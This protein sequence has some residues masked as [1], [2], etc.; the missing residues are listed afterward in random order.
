MAK[1]PKKSV[2]IL[3]GIHSVTEAL[4]AGRREF[5]EIYFSR[6]LPESIA[7]WARKRNVPVIGKS[8]EE[9]GKLAGTDQHQHVAAKV[10]P[11]L[12]ESLSRLI[13]HDIAG[14][15]SP[16]YVLIDS[17]E[18]PRNMGA[19]I[20]TS[21]C[22][23]VSGVIVPKDRCAPLTPAVSRASAGAMEHCRLC[24]VTNLTG[25]IKELKKQNVWITGLDRKGHLSIYD[26]DMTGACAIVVGGEHTGIRRL[27][28][29]NC[30]RLC[31]IPQY[32]PVNSLNAS[33]A[34]AIAIY[35]AIRQRSEENHQ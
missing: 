27:V 7:G 9:L 4:R 34:G 22:G 2:E 24:R 23:G 15:T 13:Q 32:G 16:L 5:F 1:K 3:S 18:D 30:D 35:E 14:K 29:Q 12:P 11:F 8:R 28:A 21:V 31:H 26:T 10:T 20:R 33:V 6:P 17:V 19:L 25:A